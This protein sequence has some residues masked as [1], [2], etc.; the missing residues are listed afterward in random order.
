MEDEYELLCNLLNGVI[1]S[2]LEYRLTNHL[3]GKPGM[4]GNLT[5]VREMFRGF[6]KSQGSVGEKILLGKSGLNFLLLAASLCPF[7]TLLSLCI[8][9]RFRIMPCCIPTP[10]TDNNTSTGM[11]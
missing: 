1:S 6:T 4:S 2:D 3:Y 10:T 5:A 9:F 11:I 8:S 7:M